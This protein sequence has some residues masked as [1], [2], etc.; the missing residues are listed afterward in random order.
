MK[1]YR[2]LLEFKYKGNPYI[3]YL[4]KRGKKFFLKKE[5]SGSLSYLTD[6]EFAELTLFFTTVPKVKKIIGEN[7][8]KLFPKVISGGITIALTTSIISAGLSKLGINTSSLFP[9]K[10]TSEVI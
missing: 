2:K 4:D 9:S 8:I 1:E 6:T 7:K 10:Q 5:E 3:M